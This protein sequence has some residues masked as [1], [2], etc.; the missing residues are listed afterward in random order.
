MSHTCDAAH[1]VPHELLTDRK[2]FLIAFIPGIVAVIA[3]T[4]SFISNFWCETIK[5]VPLIGSGT[6]LVLPIRSFGPFYSMEIVATTITASGGTSYAVGQQ[7]LKLPSSVYI[8]PKWVTTQ[9]FAI[10]TAIFGGVALFWTCLSPCFNIG[11]RVWK[12]L[13]FVF[14]FCSITQGLTLLF[15]ES[16][17]CNDNDM[18]NSQGIFYNSTCE[19]DWGTNTN[20]SSVVFWFLAGILMVALIPPAEAPERPPPEMQTVTYTKNP[21]GTVSE[22]GVVKGTYVAEDN[23]AAG[24]ASGDPEN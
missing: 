12:G 23:A 7:C 18:I 8:D 9:A 10:I 16:S 22:T 3:L 1:I 24:A 21:D 5:F 19:W 20:I 15:L 17:A 14:L 2:D 11:P 4:L 13:G 6:N